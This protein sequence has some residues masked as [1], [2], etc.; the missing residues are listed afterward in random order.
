MHRRNM[1]H[2]RNAS[3]WAIGQQ[4]KTG[5]H[6]RRVV[7]GLFL[8]CEEKRDGEE[9]RVAWIM[10]E[11]NFKRRKNLRTTITAGQ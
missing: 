4:T 2:A 3:A 8:A 11:K 5:F 1:K 6:V 9:I 10:V 7:W